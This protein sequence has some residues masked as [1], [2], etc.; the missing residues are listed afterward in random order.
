MVDGL[1]IRSG[2]RLGG[3]LLALALLALAPTR[4]L[5]QGTVQIDVLG[6]PPV[7]ETPFVSE[8]AQ[9]FETGRYPIR[10]LYSSPT[11]QSTTFT[12]EAIL[13]RDGGELARVASEPFALSPG[14]YTYLGFDGSM[15]GGPPILF[16]QSLA[17]LV[18]ALPPDDRETVR[19]TGALS[20]GVYTLDVTVRPLD[21]SS[22]VVGLGSTVVFQVRL[23]QP[24]ILFEPSDASQVTTDLPIF[25]WAPVIA[26]A[27]TQIEYDFLLVEI[28]AGQTALQALQSNRAYHEETVV[29]TTLLYTPDKLPLEEGNAY[30]WQVRARDPL[31]LTA[32]TNEGLSEVRTFSYTPYTIFGQSQLPIR[33]TTPTGD[34][35]VN[36]LNPSF[37][38]LYVTQVAE[39]QFLGMTAVF[40]PLGGV[41]MVESRAKP[42]TVPIVLNPT[43]GTRSFSIPPTFNKLKGGVDYMWYLTLG[44]RQVSDMGTFKYRPGGIGPIMLPL[45]ANITNPGAGESVT[46]VEPTFVWSI[47][48][49]DRPRVN[50][51][52]LIVEQDGQ[53]VVTRSVRVQPSED[54]GLPYIETLSLS[55]LL[56]LDTD[57]GRGASVTAIV[58]LNDDE[59]APAERRT[60]TY[61]P[62]LPLVLTAPR[63]QSIIAG[64]RVD[65]R[66]QGALSSELVSRSDLRME[67]V[68][69]TGT[70]ETVRV[71]VGKSDIGVTI[72]LN[73]LAQQNAAF[74]P[75]SGTTYRW[76]LELTNGSGWTARSPMASFGVAGT[77]LTLTAPADND[78]TTDPLPTFEWR[79]DGPIPS[80][81]LELVLSPSPQGNVAAPTPLRIALAPGQTRYTLTGQQALTMGTNNDGIAW[82]LH[83]DGKPVAPTRSFYYTPTL[84]ISVLRPTD[85]SSVGGAFLDLTWN[86]DLP[87]GMTGLPLEL[88]MAATPSGAQDA[89]FTTS[90]TPTVGN[91]NAAG[92][93]TARVAIASLGV[94]A[95]E[96]FDGN[97]WLRARTGSGFSWSSESVLTPLRITSTAGGALISLTSPA[98]GGVNGDPMVEFEWSWGSSGM[99]GEALTLVATPVV[100]FGQGEVEEFATQRFALQP[101]QTQFTPAAAEQWLLGAGPN[102]YVRWHLEV[103]RADRE[104]RVHLPQH[105]A[106]QPDGFGPLGRTKRALG[107]RRSGLHV[108]SPACTRRSARSAVYGLS[109]C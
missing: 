20:E 10:I 41:R 13:R 65:L 81:D 84:N 100:D 106:H 61:K 33:L 97:L 46:R 45:M 75:T 22:L 19:Q 59:K 16:A 89:S 44:E 98:N 72:D 17:S 8:L 94:T 60:F 82:T 15:E 47:K 14:V 37:N 49:E 34:F 31:E 51:M 108:G 25:S 27:G 50:Q 101:G 62:E 5:A 56:A 63:A 38:W 85:E 53:S 87:P 11:A 2:L 39:A 40:V 80:G 30:A 96:A 36:E 105:A 92:G 71:P 52:E 67:V 78:R 68:V 29:G 24:P 43:G 35:I 12:L 4:A 9:R 99:S 103:R 107:R 6:V 88:A 76:R 23:S 83:V 32:F 26:P 58:R 3:T 18:D 95:G 66:W 102:S 93:G 1:R 28:L 69:L 104:R 70:N 42:F 79:F 86:V 73:A 55:E 77:Q 74:T 48:K 64:S 54:V 57:R 109:G 21:P 90:Q 91:V 7:L